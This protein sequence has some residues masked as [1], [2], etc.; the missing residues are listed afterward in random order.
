MS[1]VAFT[2]LSLFFFTLLAVLMRYAM[3]MPRYFS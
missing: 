2:L 1:V 3:M